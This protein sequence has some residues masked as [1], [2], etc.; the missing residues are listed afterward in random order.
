MSRRDEES[1]TAPLEVPTFEHEPS[2]DIMVDYARELDYLPGLTKWTPS[3]LDNGGGNVV[4]SAHDEEQQA[5]LIAI[6]K[7]MGM[8]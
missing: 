7:N 6:L 1:S 3:G 5:R 2:E 4:S 8:Y